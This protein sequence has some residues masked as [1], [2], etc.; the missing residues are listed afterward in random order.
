MK[1]YLDWRIYSF[2]GV[3]KKTDHDGGVVGHDM[4]AK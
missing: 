4:Q 2:Q 1:S 3:I